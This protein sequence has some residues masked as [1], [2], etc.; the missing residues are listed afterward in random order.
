MKTSTKS[1]L[2]LTEEMTQY[3]YESY[4]TMMV[5]DG[6]LED[7][8]LEEMGKRYTQAL[9]DAMGTTREILTSQI[10]QRSWGLDAD[11]PKDYITEVDF[12]GQE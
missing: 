11:V 3:Q 5:L 8:V 2:T 9:A 4:G 6:E 1:K 12:N 7:E 10:L